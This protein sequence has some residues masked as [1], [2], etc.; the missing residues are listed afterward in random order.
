MIP[1]GVD[2]N[3]I[4]DVL[5]PGVHSATLEEVEA[6]FATTHV[7]KNLFDGF[8]RGVESLRNAG[9][10]V[11]FLD[12]SFVTEKA[13]PGDFDACWDPIGVNPGELDPV[14]LDFSENRRR[15]KAKYGGEF[16]PSSAKADGT[17]TFEEFF[18]VDTHSGK[19][20]GIIRIRLS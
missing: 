3:G 13:T 11:V 17:R 4:W 6:R 15:Q 12:G 19:P 8:L 16:F 18:Q 7:R 20:K 2:V 14:L 9:C 5:P 10:R 1:G